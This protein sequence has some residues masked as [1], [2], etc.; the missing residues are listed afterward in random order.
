MSCLRPSSFVACTKHLD[1][2]L[3]NRNCYME[4]PASQPL[5]ERVQSLLAAWNDHDAQRAAAFYA[6]D[7]VGEDVGQAQPQHGPADR[8]RVL[9]AYV[10]GFPDLHFTGDVMVEGEKAVLLWNMQGTHKGRFLN[11]P[12]TGRRVEIRGVS[13]LHFRDD[14]IVRGVNIWDMAGLLRSLGLLPELS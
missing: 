1:Q 12:P 14:K 9:E 6:D 11:I 10:R 3:C 13:V 2:H 5:A 4:E 8:V 7:Y